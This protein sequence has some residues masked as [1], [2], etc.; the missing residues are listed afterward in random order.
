MQT[1]TFNRLLKQLKSLAPMQKGKV[2]ARLHQES[3]IDILTG[4]IETLQ[5][6][7]HCSSESYQKWEGRSGL[8]R[9]CCHKTYNA[10]TGTPLARLRH[11]EVWSD[12]VED[13]ID[14]K[15]IRAR[16]AQCGVHGN[17]AFRW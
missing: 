4:T 7:P 8:Q 2:D 5:Q 9:Y 16:A 15:R 10:L 17:T 1:K 6:C 11:K 14:S 13:I 12:F 3:V